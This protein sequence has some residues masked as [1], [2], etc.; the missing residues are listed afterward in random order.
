MKNIFGVEQVCLVR[1]L[2]NV[3]KPI[4]KYYFMRRKTNLAKLFSKNLSMV[5][6]RFKIHRGRIRN[7]KLTDYLPLNIKQTFKM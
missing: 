4:P 6:S 2:H 3:Q 7:K 5:F 1:N